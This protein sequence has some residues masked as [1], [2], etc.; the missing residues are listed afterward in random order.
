VFALNRANALALTCMLVGVS[1]RMALAWVNREANDDHVEV[2]LKL[3]DGGA[4]PTILTC[5]ECFQPK[6]FHLLWAW[7]A[8]VLHLSTRDQIAVAGQII[9]ALSGTAVLLLGCA[10]IGRIST[11]PLVRFLG[12]SWLALNPGLLAI[13]VQATNDSLIILTGTILLVSLTSWIRSGGD[14]RIS[15]VAVVLSAGFAPH[16]KSNGIVLAVLT[17]AIVAATI[18]RRSRTHRHLRSAA[19]L[20]LFALVIILGATVNRSYQD[21]YRVTG[22]LLPINMA[23]APAPYFFQ[24]TIAYRPGVTSIASA[25]FTFRIFDLV[26][27]PFIVDGGTPYSLHRTSLWSQLYGRTYFL[28]FDQWPPSWQD[29][30]L[31]LRVVG[32]ALFVL[33]LLPTWLLVWGSYGPFVTC[34]GSRP[35]P[36]CSCCS[37]ARCSPSSSRTV[38]DIVTWR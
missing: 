17:A 34:T 19:A 22:H 8:R 10:F 29:Q 38:F 35:R 13:N 20:L 21:N 23:P 3:L 14:R 11:S 37:P 25:F 16:V 26:E 6:F 15:F 2:V 30:S 4:Q 33:G 36:S 24:H 1:L 18:W 12:T 5:N 27:T 31:S 7:I 32:R 9:N 28:H